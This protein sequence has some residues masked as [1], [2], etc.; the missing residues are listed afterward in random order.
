VSNTQYCYAQTQ[1]ETKTFNLLFGCSV[2]DIKTKQQQQKKKQL[3]TFFPW[4]TLDTWSFSLQLW[5]IQYD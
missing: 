1:G 3:L 4:Y 2:L 5:S